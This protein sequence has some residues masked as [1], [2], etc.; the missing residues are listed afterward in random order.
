MARVRSSLTE[1]LPAP[2]PGGLDDDDRDRLSALAIEHATS[3][4]RRLPP[5][6][7]SKMDVAEVGEFLMRLVV[8]DPQAPSAELEATL[9]RAM[10]LD[11]AASDTIGSADPW[12][13]PS[14]GGPLSLLAGFTLEEL[15]RLI[16]SVSEEELSAARDPARTLIYD[17]PRMAEVIELAYG[18]GVAGFGPLRLM[19][20]AEPHLGIIA[21]LRASRAGLGSSLGAL[22][23]SCRSP[24]VQQVLEVLLPEARTFVRAHPQRRRIEQDGL[25]THSA[26]DAAS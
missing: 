15:H 3:L 18:R 25:L 1:A 17:M 21:A 9:S 13:D 2:P 10:G 16:D 7:L 6:K 23:E 20:P 11:R 4:R 22:V 24:Q 26:A 8:G 12:Y 14:S 19:S 5:A